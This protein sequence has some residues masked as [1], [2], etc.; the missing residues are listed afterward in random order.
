MTDP[1]PEPDAPDAPEPEPTPTP[2]PEPVDQAAE[3]EKWKHFAREHERSA[4][5][6]AAAARKLQEIEDAA[7]SQAEKDAEA[8]AA[9]EARAAKAEADLAR[10]KVATAKGIPLE[11]VD[12]LIGADETE[13][14]ADADRLLSVIKPATPAAPGGSADGGPQGAPPKPAALEARI[15]EA[16]AKGDV[17]GFIAL[18][19]L[20]LGATAP[21]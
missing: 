3:L 16:Q 2:E 10:L 4:K 5:A 11:L 18:Q 13:L 21:G 20:K 7:K 15:A 17:K 19:N 6:N 9:A 12:R 1:T 8:K 14:A